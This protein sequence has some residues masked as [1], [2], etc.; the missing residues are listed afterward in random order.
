LTAG[1]AI[2]I[3]IWSQEDQGDN[4]PE[5][6]KRNARIEGVA[7]RVE[8]R[9]GNACKLEF[10]DESF[11]VV[12]SSSAIHNIHEKPARDNAIREIMRVLKPGGQV[13]IYDIK[14]IH[15]Y[16]E[17]F[18][19]SGMEQVELSGWL[20]WYLPFARLLTATKPKGSNT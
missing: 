17:I 19:N 3:D 14:V 6:T 11:D 10:P 20:R 12:L 16:K 7:D 4:S 8:V 9:D 5:N 2:G 18:D 13:A 1:R 15:E